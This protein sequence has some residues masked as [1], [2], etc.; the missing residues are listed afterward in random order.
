[1]KWLVGLVTNQLT[2]ASVDDGRPIFLQI[3][4]SLEGQI[5]DGSMAEGSQVP[6]INEL[7]AFHRI[8]PA[9]ALKG[10]NMLVDAGLLIKRRGIGM[11]V[12][13]GA[14]GALL[15]QRRAEFQRAHVAPLTARAK[16]LGITITELQH[17]TQE[18]M[19]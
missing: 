14:R 18:E 7:A 16:A 13:D 4:E 2:G 11:F 19:R 9:T 17:M 8:N 5:L 12:A 1:M 10:V 3:A 6:S 15:A